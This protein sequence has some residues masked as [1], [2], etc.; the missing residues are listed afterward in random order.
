MALLD[1]G[2]SDVSDLPNVNEVNAF[3]IEF[4]FE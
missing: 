4:I 1:I 3:L 2:L